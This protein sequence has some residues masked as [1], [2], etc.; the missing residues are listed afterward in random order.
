MVNRFPNSMKRLHLLNKAALSQKERVFH[1][2]ILFC[3][4]ARIRSRSP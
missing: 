4:L 3:F 2:I 1:V